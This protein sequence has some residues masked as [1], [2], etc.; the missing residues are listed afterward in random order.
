MVDALVVIVGPTAVGKT[1]LS[2]PLAQ[3]IH[4]EIVNVDSRQMYR[5]LDVGTAKPTP[6][7]TSC[8]ASSSA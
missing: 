6:L 5:Y 8:R 2:L 1:A 4:A 3:A 7:R